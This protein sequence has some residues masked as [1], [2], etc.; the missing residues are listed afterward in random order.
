MYA[1]AVYCV[2]GCNVWH[3]VCSFWSRV[4]CVVGPHFPVCVRLVPIYGPHFPAVY[5]WCLGSVMCVKTV[6]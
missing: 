6:M 1:R 2:V 3:C 5:D 4:Y